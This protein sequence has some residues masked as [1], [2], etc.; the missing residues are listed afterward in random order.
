MTTITRP[1]A[2]ILHAEDSDDDAFVVKRALS[3][4]GVD[5][6]VIRVTNGMQALMYLRDNPPP[7]LL[8]LDLKMPAL[9]GFDVLVT[10]RARPELKELP[11]I[12]LTASDVPKDREMADQF[13]ATDYIEKN[14]DWKI[15]AKALKSSLRRMLGT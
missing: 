15:V 8:L 13:G 10:I 12:V 7:D 3:E 6:N 1:T 9:D 4:I 5:L 2:K 14:Q 11:V